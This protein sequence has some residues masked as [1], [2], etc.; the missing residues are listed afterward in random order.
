MRDDLLFVS[1]E[2]EEADNSQQGPEDERE[3]RRPQSLR[4]QRCQ[5]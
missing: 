5:T 1:A 4:R 3:T 2:N